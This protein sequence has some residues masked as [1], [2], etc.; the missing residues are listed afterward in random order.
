[1]RAAVFEAIGLPLAVRNLPD[2]D[3]LDDELVIQVGR[4]GVCGTDLHMTEGHGLFS[5]AAGC[6]L[7]HEFAGEV[8][9]IGRSVEGWAVGDRL[10]AMPV[11]TCGR[12]A[13][14]LAGVPL[15]CAQ[16]ANQFGGF[17]QYARVQALGAIRLPVGVA[18]ADAALVEPLAVALHGMLRADIVAGCSVVVLGAGPIGLAAAFWARRLGAGRITVVECL[19]RRRE[20]ALAMGVDRA[21]SPEEAARANGS[22]DIVVEA[23]GRPG[24]LAAAIDHVRMG[25][26]IVSLGFC[27]TADPF[28]PALAACKE[29]SIRFPLAWTRRDFEVSVDVLARGAVEPRTM[30]TQS[31]GLDEFPQAFE[32]LRQPSDQCKILLDPWK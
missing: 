26:G 27:M 25:G 19:P 7:G 22:S 18:L 4:C 32:A 11:R 24:M 1:M 17:G 5:A 15:Q 29:V 2:P 21:L 6:V 30:L 23:V 9:A 20:I 10:A 28:T 8:V 13:A 31:F 12:C 14:C 16:Y 3:P